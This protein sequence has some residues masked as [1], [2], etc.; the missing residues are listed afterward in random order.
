MLSRGT[1][2]WVGR[3]FCR[4]NL[5][6]QFM[7][8]ALPPN[9]HT[10]V[11]L[12]R[13]STAKKNLATRIADSAIPNG[14]VASNATMTHARIKYGV[15]A[16]NNSTTMRTTVRERVVSPDFAARGDWEAL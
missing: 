1:A 3:L 4:R 6:H 12:I 14:R 5:S 2:R 9:T 8:F 10:S 13:S 11:A 16:A 7:L 15:R